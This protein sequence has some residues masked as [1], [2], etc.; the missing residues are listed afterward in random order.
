[1]DSIPA[2]PSIPVETEAITEVVKSTLTEPAFS[3]IGLGGYW[4]TGIVQSCLEFLHIG[5]DLP[6]W[7]CIAVGMKITLNFSSNF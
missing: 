1:M 2:P 7:G 5:F 4:P 6:W 3:D